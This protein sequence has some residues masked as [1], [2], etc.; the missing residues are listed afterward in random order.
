MFRF[1]SHANN[2]NTESKVCFPTMLATM[3]MRA[4]MIKAITMIMIMIMTNIA[5]MVIVMVMNMTAKM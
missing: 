2:L 3:M 1:G 5:T 4:R